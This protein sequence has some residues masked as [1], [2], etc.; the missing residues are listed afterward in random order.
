MDPERGAD[1]KTHRSGKVSGRTSRGGRGACRERSE[2]ASG[3]GRAAGAG[4]PGLT[5]RAPPRARAP[6]GDRAA[7][8]VSEKAGWPGELLTAGDEAC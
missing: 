6:A 7:L 1:K 2:G 5:G 4:W 3:E 8:Q